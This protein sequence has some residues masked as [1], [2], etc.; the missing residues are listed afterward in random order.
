MLGKSDTKALQEKLDL[1][2]AEN[3]QLRR[4]LMLLSGG[5]MQGS[6]TLGNLTSFGHTRVPQAQATIAGL[7]VN[8]LIVDD[9]WRII[10]MNTRMGEFLGVNKDI[11]N[12]KPPL[13]EY[14]SLDW[15]P[16][17]FRTLLQDAHES[18]GEEIFEAERPDPVSGRPQFYQFKAVWAESQG[19]ITVEDIS[20]L[21][22]TR[23]FFERLVSPRIV[24]RLLDSSEDPFLSHKR[25]MSVLFADL[26]SFTTFCEAVDAPVVQSVFNE[27]VDVCMRAIEANDATLDKFVGDQ[28]MALF[29]APLPSEGHAY[30]AV[31]FAVDLQQNMQRT[32]RMWIQQ[33]LLP[34]ALVD[35]YPEILTL[36]VG[37]NSGDMLLGMFGGQKANQYTTLGHHVNLS[38][39]LCSFAAGNEVLASLG[40]VQEISKYAKANPARIAIPIKFRTKAQIEV[41]GIA[42]P[43]TVATLAYDPG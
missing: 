4:K 9:R 31:K 10:R 27:F 16:G 7:S 18:R 33:G 3:E 12:Q 2:Q 43:V 39:R 37:I 23:Q 11:V 22:T 5:Q 26:R 34:Q 32:R 24:E 21:R 8:Y 15:A 42:E 40:T 35:K 25:T 19:T 38:A 14:D 28:V 41:K 36:G 29:G 1:L 20:R 13:A 17:V 6:M 30:N